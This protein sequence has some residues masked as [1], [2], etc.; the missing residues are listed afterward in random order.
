MRRFFG[1]RC[2][3]VWL[4]LAPVGVMA[5]ME[6]LSVTVS[7]RERIALPPGAELDL[8]ILGTAHTDGLFGPIASQRFA[9]Q[10]VPM[11]VALT[12]DPQIVVT[13]AG[14]TL[15]AAIRTPDGARMFR[16]VRTFD[17]TN[18][19]PA[20]IDL[21]LAMPPE[22]D[23]DAAV[24]RRISGIAWTVTEILGEP[25]PGHDPAT[26]VI[27]DAMNVS[28]FGGCNRFRGRLP[29]SAGGLAFDQNMA[30]TLM[31][32]PGEIE[33]AERRFLS[34]LGLVADYVRYGAGLVMTDARGRAVLHFIET[35]E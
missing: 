25:W 7:Y 4:V 3:V 16:A 32:C 8:R 31:A 5:Q 11:T 35:P 10:A 14:Y 15:F 29:P 17:T 2:L 12:Y 1:I 34:A 23:G 9:M 28:V 19:I 6:T 30:G 26:L 33:Q 22:T 24:P 13:A 27:D 21:L 20:A 18:P